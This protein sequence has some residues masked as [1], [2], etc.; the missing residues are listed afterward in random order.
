MSVLQSLSKGFAS[1]LKSV[2]AKQEALENYIVIPL[3][4]NHEIRFRITGVEIAF[5]AKTRDC[6][7]ISILP[8]SLNPGG[9]SPLTR[10][11]YS[12]TDNDR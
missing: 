12:L 1:S 5:G 4:C 3:I 7:L 11:R 8:I 10:D 9:K 6:F 2:L